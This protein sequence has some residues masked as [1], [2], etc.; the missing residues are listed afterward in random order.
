VLLT[1]IAD[2]GDLLLPV[3]PMRAWGATGRSAA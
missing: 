1:D 3:T 2:P